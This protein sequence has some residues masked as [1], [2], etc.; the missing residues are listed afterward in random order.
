MPNAVPVT[1]WN[2]RSPV[3]VTV[4]SHSIPPRRFSSC[5]YV[6]EPTGRSTSFAH[7]HWSSSSEPGPETSILANDVSSN[8]AAVVRVARASA[9]IAGLQ[10]S[11]AQPRG[12]SAS[13]SAAVS[14]APFGSNQFG[15]SHD[16][17]SPNDA[18]SA[19]RRPY[20]GDRRSGRPD[21]RSSFG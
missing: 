18:P 21:V 12:R 10:I 4:R 15:R 16:D 1:S 17:F 7:S 8:S 5:V 19:S 14:P 2:R 6:T 11:P 20:A 9:P 13:R 3:R